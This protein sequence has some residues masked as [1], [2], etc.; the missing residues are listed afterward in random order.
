MEDARPNEA[1][2]ARGQHTPQSGGRSD[3]S[4][5]GDQQDVE[6]EKDNKGQGSPA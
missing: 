2:H 3:R 6:R 4:H 1:G 5:R